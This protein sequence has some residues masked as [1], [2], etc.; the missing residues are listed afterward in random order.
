MTC[1]ITAVRPADHSNQPPRRAGAQSGHVLDVAETTFDLLMRGPAPL[2]VDGAALG[3]GLPAREIA[4]DE[5]RAILL[6]PSTG[7]DARDAVWKV[8]VR[9]ARHQGPSWVIGC[10]GVALPG[11]K[12]IVRDRL[13]GLESEP[14]A[15]TSRVAGDLLS[16]FLEALHQVDLEQPRIA[17]RLVWRSAKAVERAYRA[18]VQVIPVDPSEL[19][20]VD[21]A[22]VSSDDHVDLLLGSAVRQG[23]ITA[24]EA[25][26]ITMTRLE[27]MAP[28]CLA[29]RLGMSYAAFMK[30]RSRAEKRLV[31][32][33]RDEGLRDD[34][35]SLMSKP[36]V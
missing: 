4:L 10:V 25:E 9:R 3:H 16:A 22:A 8:L 19:V 36:G 18:H 7:H 12:A 15:D 35:A 1:A 33:M 14:G 28:A 17:Q 31:A 5:V 24:V 26:I 21:P 6:H 20:N 29:G 2:S 23:V 27:G 13:R 32:A 11:L 30:R 34:F